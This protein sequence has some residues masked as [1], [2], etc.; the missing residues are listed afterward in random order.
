M[1]LLRYFKPKKL[2][3]TML[4]IY[5]KFISPCLPQSCRFKTSCSGYA[6]HSIKDFGLILG[7]FWTVSRIFRCNPWNTTLLE[8]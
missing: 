3:L 2:I 5:K 4:E 7:G 6:I 8:D 1:K